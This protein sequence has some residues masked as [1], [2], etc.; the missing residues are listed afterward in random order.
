MTV[1]RRLYTPRQVL[2]RIGPGHENDNL[3]AILQDMAINKPDR[4]IRLEADGWHDDQ[5]YMAW[6]NGDFTWGGDNCQ[7]HPCRNAPEIPF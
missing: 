5:E 1:R 4:M 3:R 2:D 7:C 6:C